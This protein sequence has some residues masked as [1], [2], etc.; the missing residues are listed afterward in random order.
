MCVLVL[1][2][3][4]G[5]L[6]YGKY[7]C[8]K[9]FC[10]TPP[11][12]RIVH[13]MLSPSVRKLR[14]ARRHFLLKFLIEV[15]CYLSV[16]MQKD[17]SISERDCVRSYVWFR[18]VTVAQDLEI[19]QLRDEAR[20]MRELADRLRN[21]LRHVRRDEAQRMRELADRRRNELR[22]VARDEAQRMRELA[23]CCRNELREF[24][25]RS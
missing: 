9:H 24:R 14:H 15:I 4:A 11:Q 17:V 1:G 7:R 12:K 5:E 18:T 25:H 3:I 2:G 23:D 19:R 8:R 21:E 16:Q 13:E 20:Q 22:D 10:C 6:E